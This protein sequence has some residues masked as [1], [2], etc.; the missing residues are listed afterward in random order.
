MIDSEARVNGG[1]E[2]SRSVEDDDDLINQMSGMA[3]GGGGGKSKQ[4]SVKKVSSDEEEEEMVDEEKG[5]NVLNKDNPIFKDEAVSSKITTLITVR[6]QLA[7]FGL[8][9][10]HLVNIHPPSL[11]HI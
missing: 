11:T 9:Q 8:Y 7:S 3:I 4:S 6:K 1:L 2:D 10:L 5:D